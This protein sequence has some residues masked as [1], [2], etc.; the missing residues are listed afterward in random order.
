MEFLNFGMKHR[1]SKNPFLRF[2]ASI[3]LFFVK[4]E[5]ERIEK[6]VEKTEI[7]FETLSAE[8][9]LRRVK[10]REKEEDEI[11]KKG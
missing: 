5:T 4:K 3:C 7:D 9:M 2:L 10:Q 8:E 1:K 11:A 6:K